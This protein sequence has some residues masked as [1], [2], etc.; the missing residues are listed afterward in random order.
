[1]SRMPAAER[2]RQLLEC[3]AKLFAKRGYARATTA[4]LASAA[5][6][7]EPIIYRHFKSKRDLFIAL[8]DQSGEETLRMWQR[9][10]DGIADP[11]ERL[12]RLLGDNPMVAGEGRDAYRVLLQGITVADDPQVHDAIQRHVGRLHQFLTAEIELAQREHRVVGRFDAAL[13]AWLLIDVGMGY[14]V[15]KGLK[16]EGQGLGRDGM[17]VQELVARI[18]VGPRAKD[19]G[20]ERTTAPA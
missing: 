7:T 1:M 15:L 4:E 5:G 18:L 12:L 3:A 14:G 17:H 10:L 2:R 8:I 13:I 6:V 9:D 20:E 19:R 11:S 16:V